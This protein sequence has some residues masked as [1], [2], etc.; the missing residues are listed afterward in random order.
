M[1]TTISFLDRVEV[2]APCSESWE[3]MAGDDR[4]RHCDLCRHNVYN[5]SG[6]TRR[7]AESLVLKAGE[8]RTCVRFYRRTDGTV[9]TDN[10]PVG[11]R[12]IRVDPRS[13]ST[14]AREYGVTQTAIS[15]L[16]S[17]RR[18]QSLN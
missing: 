7:E 1:K 6:M 10:C 3:A 5:L 9:L 18:W 12:A 8:Q 17:G 14:I 15:L 16:K 4:T 11:L 13:Q 2:A